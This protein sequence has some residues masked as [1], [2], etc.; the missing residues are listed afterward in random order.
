[1]LKPSI[2]LIFAL[3]MFVM[4]A[5]AGG[6]APANGDAAGQTL[7]PGDEIRIIV[8]KDPDLTCDCLV[9]G[10]LKVFPDRHQLILKTQRCLKV[11]ADA[12]VVGSLYFK[13]CHAS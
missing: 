10:R 4:V 1:M 3:A 13:E 2:R 8:Y 12:S 11:F 7:S 5:P 9:A 6:Q